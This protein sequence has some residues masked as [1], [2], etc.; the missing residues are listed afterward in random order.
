MIW[1]IGFCSLRCDS[2]VIMKLPNWSFIAYC[3]ISIV[4]D[5]RPWLK[6]SLNGLHPFHKIFPIFTRAALILN[7]CAVVVMQSVIT[8]LSVFSDWGSSPIS[9][10]NYIN[11]AMLLIGWWGLNFNVSLAFS[12]F[13]SDVWY[14][15]VVSP[16][17]FTR[18]ARTSPILS[19][20]TK[21]VSLANVHE[22]SKG[23]YNPSVL[24]HIFRKCSFC[25]TRKVS[26]TSDNI[27]FFANCIAIPL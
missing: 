17:E 5:T 26:L 22:G 16:T 25:T 6:I 1:H 7:E 20:E 18:N 12:T 21:W 11:K 13:I 27:T 2:N 4:H 3:F 10:K 9:I 24:V 8:S 15:N 14:S 23:L 19:W